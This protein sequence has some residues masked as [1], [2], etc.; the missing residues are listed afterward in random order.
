MTRRLGL[1]M[2]L[3]VAVPA[4]AADTAR[5]PL[6][7]TLAPGPHAVGFTKIEIADAS[8]PSR[9]AL[10]GASTPDARAR[11]I[12]VHVWYPAA[13]SSAAAP[14]TFGDAMVTHLTGRP[15]GT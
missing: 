3:L 6:H 8:R 7:G 13:T 9:R 12:V 1:C 15:T 4:F 11:R 5:S 2:A 10:E 14:M